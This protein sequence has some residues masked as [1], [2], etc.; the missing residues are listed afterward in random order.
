VEPGSATLWAWIRGAIEHAGLLPAA[1]PTT[2]GDSGQ[3]TRTTL[4]NLLRALPEPITLVIDDVDY[5]ADPETFDSLLWLLQRTEN[6]R[7]I[8]SARSLYPA[9][10]A[11]TAAPLHAVTIDSGTLGFTANETL[12]VAADQGV[13]LNESAAAYITTQL[14]GWPLGVQLVVADLRG[15]GAAP[16]AHERVHA[17]L[18]RV[19]HTVVARRSASEANSPRLH[20]LRRTSVTEVLH[21]TLA[22]TL[23]GGAEYREHLDWALT[24]GIAQRDL[25]GTVRLIPLIRS[26]LETELDSRDPIESINLRRAVGRWA[27]HAGETLT[28]LGM[29]ARIADWTLLAEVLRRHATAA[30]HRHPSTVQ[31][32]LRT[33]P[34]GIIS[35]HPLLVT[36]Y[37]LTLDADDVLAMEHLRAIVNTGEGSLRHPP[38]DGRPEL[39]MWTLACRMILERLAG[40]YPNAAKEADAL[41]ACLTEVSA[42]HPE[43]SDTIAMLRMQTG[44]TFTF[45]GRFTDALRVFCSERNAEQQWRRVKASCLMA[46]CHAIRGD[47]GECARLLDQVGD[48]FPPSER[49]NIH[50]VIAYYLARSLLSLETFDVDGAASQLRELNAMRKAIEYRPVVMRTELMITLARGESLSDLDRVSISAHSRRAMRASSALAPLIAVGRADLLVAAGYPERALEELSSYS[51]STPQFI[52]GEARA[53]LAQNNPAEASTLVEELVWDEALLSRYRA[54]ALLLRA[55][56][57]KCIG[58]E[59]G[60][61]NSLKRALAILDDNG[62]RRPLMMVPRRELRELLLSLRF[63]N[64]Q[65][66]ER[67]L[68]GVPDVFPSPSGV[69]PLTPRECVVLDTLNRMGTVE[70]TA[71]RLFVSANTVKSQLRSIYRKLGVSSRDEA[72]AIARER[73]ILKPRPSGKL[74]N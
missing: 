34:V 40:N 48:G 3:L 15:A 58:Y 49:K 5:S 8:T 72:L 74:R 63:W 73:G 46:L 36:I 20:Y 42:E 6:L 64:G 13:L 11:R 44:I 41:A 14:A 45:V 12:R 10:S 9:A 62:L 57:L 52:L 4:L 17:A 30:L 54:E 69:V 27:C 65:P 70:S 25:E 43:L 23:G 38:P 32:V 31:S 28:A 66:A 55:V 60:A 1:V 53:R 33:V 59:D 26:A 68:D 39:Q 56:S 21:P 71:E 19:A 37:A 50:A 67:L 16:V 29:A 51:V 61:V 18:R 24:E 7:L 35:R 47:M 2:H 22:A